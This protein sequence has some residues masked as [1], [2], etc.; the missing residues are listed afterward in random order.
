MTDASARSRIELDVVAVAGN[1]NADRP[2]VLAL[3]EA[4][5]GVAV[6]TITDLRKLERGKAILGERAEVNSAK[7]LL[8]SRSGFERDL[9]DLAAQ[10]DDVELV[11]IERLYRG[12]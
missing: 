7:L 5:G 11:D 8:F 12:H 9:L 6:R 3:G 2:L 10:R 4:K 1:P